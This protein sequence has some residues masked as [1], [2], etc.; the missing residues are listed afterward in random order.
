[1]G[2][3]LGMDPLPVI[4]AAAL[5]ITIITIID[6]IKTG[7]V[8]LV[9]TGPLSTQKTKTPQNNIFISVVIA[10]GAP[11]TM[12][13]AEMWRSMTILSGLEAGMTSPL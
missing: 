3:E 8:I 7:V 5:K 6:W 13:V 9:S 4:L 10:G 12:P 1:M 2:V 11:V